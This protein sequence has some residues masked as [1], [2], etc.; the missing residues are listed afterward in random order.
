[1][2]NAVSPEEL[3][4][5][6]LSLNRWAAAHAPPEESPLRKRL[7]EHLGRAPAE[8][9]VVSRELAAWDRANLQ[10]ALDVY[11]VRGEA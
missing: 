1:M 5:A 11:L 4:A 8:L 3:A 10:V 7:G 2:G 9:P 6:L